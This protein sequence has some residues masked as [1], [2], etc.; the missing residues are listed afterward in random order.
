[1]LNLVYWEWNCKCSDEHQILAPHV[2]KIPQIIIDT[3]EKYGFI[4]G[5]KWYHHDTMHFALCI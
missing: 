1:M 3:F 4:W 2:N 5:E